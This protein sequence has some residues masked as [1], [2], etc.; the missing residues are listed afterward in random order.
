MGKIEGLVLSAALVSTELYAAAS[1]AFAGGSC[2]D[3]NPDCLSAPLVKV[4]DKPNYTVVAYGRPIGSGVDLAV[5]SKTRFLGFLW[6]TNDGKKKA[7]QDILEAC[8]GSN[9]SN[10]EVFAGPDN[11]AEYALKDSNCLNSIPTG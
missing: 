3:R 7:V 11:E 1:P 4:V 8:G 9:G 10:L 6:P 5:L 2:P